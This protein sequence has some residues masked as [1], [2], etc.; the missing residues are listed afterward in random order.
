M[1]LRIRA[2][3]PRIGT[4]KGDLMD[5]PRDE[6]GF[7]VHDDDYL[8]GTPDLVAEQIVEQCRATGAGHF[9][10]ILGRG[11]ENDRGETQTLFGQEVIPILKRAKIPGG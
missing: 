7:V 5:A 8:M 1:S 3:D 2:G 9:L 11:V 4:D 6:K 10:A